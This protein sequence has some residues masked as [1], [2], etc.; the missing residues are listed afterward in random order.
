MNYILPITVTVSAPS[1]ER[2]KQ[3]REHVDQLFQS[4]MVR[5]LIQSRG[6]PYEGANVGEPRAYGALWALPVWVFLHVASH[7]QAAQSKSLAE[8]LFQDPSTRGLVRANGVPMESVS[9]GNA[10]PYRPPQAT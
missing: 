7:D 10:T 1:P 5:I 3:V 9:I 4:P 2:A 8:S 6:I